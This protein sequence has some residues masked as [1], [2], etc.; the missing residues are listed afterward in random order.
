MGSCF[1][2][3]VVA[4]LQ[5]IPG[6]DS[7]VDGL[8][9]PPHADADAPRTL[10]KP[11]RTEPSLSIRDPPKASTALRVQQ[12]G[13]SMGHSFP[14]RASPNDNQLVPGGDQGMTPGAQVL[15]LLLATNRTVNVGPP[16]STLP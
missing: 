12:R 4:S 6:E 10:R 3:R 15:G 11:L 16:A 9:D 14:P 7:R 13:W 2:A 1:H 8:Q 5:T